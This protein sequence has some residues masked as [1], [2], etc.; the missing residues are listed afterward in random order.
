VPRNLSKNFFKQNGRSLNTAEVDSLEPTSFPRESIA[1]LATVIPTKK[2]TI[3]NKYLE[4]KKDLNDFVSRGNFKVYSRLGTASIGA[5]LFLLVFV[6]NVPLMK[7][8]QRVTGKYAVFSSKPLTLATTDQDLL[9]IDSRAAKIESAFEFFNC[10]LRGYGEKFVEEADKND[11]PY[12]V[13]ASIAF[14][15][16]SCG[17]NTPVKD[18]VESYN[19][20]GWATYGDQVYM[21]DDYDQG[22]EVVSKYLNNRFYSRGITDL[23][24]IM[25]VYTPPSNGSWCKGVGYFKD[26]I[27]DYKTPNNE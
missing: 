9:F 14:Q 5:A 16:S 7:A 18:G 27:L 26:F 11:L 19:A 10:P 4:I 13:V 22:I 25:K 1:T 17:K 3:I 12:W 8:N 2:D 20:W 15:E 23:C 21:F 6:F 24:D